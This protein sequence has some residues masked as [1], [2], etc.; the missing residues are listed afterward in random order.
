[1]ANETPPTQLLQFFNPNLELFPV[2]PPT[3]HIYELSFVTRLYQAK[4]RRSFIPL[5]QWKIKG[6][7]VEEIRHSIWEKVRPYLAR[8]VNIEGWSEKITP[9]EDDL[10]KFVLFDNVVRKRRFGLDY[11]T[12]KT[13]EDWGKKQ[14]I[15]MNVY[16]YSMG[17][18]H[19]LQW[20]LFKKKLFESQ[21]PMWNE[22]ESLVKKLKKIHEKKFLSFDWK[23]WAFY[24]Q[25]H[26]PK[27]HERLLYQDPPKEIAHLFIPPNTIDI[28]SKDIEEK[29]TELPTSKEIYAL[30]DISTKDISNKNKLKKCPFTGCKSVIK[31]SSMS[32]HFKYC[33]FN[34]HRKLLYRCPYKNCGRSYMSKY[35]YRSHLTSC[36]YNPSRETKPLKKCPYC[37]ASVLNLNSHLASKHGEKKFMCDLCGVTKNTKASLEIHVRMIHAEEKYLCDTCSKEY[38]SKISLKLH[39]LRD[40]SQTPIDMNIKCN[41]CDYKTYSRTNLLRHMRNHHD[42]NHMK[43][44]CTEC[45]QNF[46]DNRALRNHMLTHANTTFACELCDHVCKTKIGLKCHMTLH[47]EWKYKCPVCG[48]KRRSAHE[49]RM[50]CKRI[51]PDYKLPPKRTV[52]KKPSN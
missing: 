14:N 15:I 11:L 36:S 16:Q 17:I 13:L 21:T 50:H 27:S 1:M 5:G 47:E 25:A 35:L 23:I 45:G 9:T 8:E 51:H 24:I 2:Q 29:S 37:P 42:P 32:Y 19:Y 44:V 46:C 18:S 12:T 52:L 4:V 28:T 38:K 30:M 43:P 49:V 6:S 7:S 22:T 40:H 41:S 48:L 3:E 20:R 31:I 26:D 34:P 10:E 39:I 33:K